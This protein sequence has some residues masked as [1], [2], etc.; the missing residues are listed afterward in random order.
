MEDFKEEVVMLLIDKILN[1]SSYFSVCDVEKLGKTLGYNVKSHPDYKYLNALH[2]THYADMSNELKSKIPVMIMNC[3]SNQFDS[4]LI[5]KAL[6]AVKGGEV[7]DLPNTEDDCPTLR[8][9]KR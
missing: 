8:L 3:V 7:K 6:L 2:C 1:K 5:T 9:I 4:S